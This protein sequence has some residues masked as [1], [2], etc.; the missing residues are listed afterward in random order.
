MG[1]EGI[2]VWI[3]EKDRI[4]RRQLVVETLPR[5]SAWASDP[6]HSI[7]AAE[8][9]QTL[10]FKPKFLGIRVHLLGGTSHFRCRDGGWRAGG[11]ARVWTV[12]I[13]SVVRDEIFH[14]NIE[15]P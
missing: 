14:R 4:A 2:E 13:F 8:F 3:I 9:Q 6:R 15:V 12:D 10:H 11:F 5:L 1:E 7:T